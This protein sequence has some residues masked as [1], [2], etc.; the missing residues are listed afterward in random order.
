MDMLDDMRML[1][2]LSCK[3]VQKLYMH[4]NAWQSRCTVLTSESFLYTV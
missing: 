4:G 1:L 3:A 2:M